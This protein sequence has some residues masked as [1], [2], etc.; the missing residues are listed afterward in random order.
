MGR[1]TLISG[2][3]GFF[4][5]VLTVGTVS[6]L[7]FSLRLSFSFS[8]LL[9][10]P[11]LLNVLNSKTAAAES[12]GSLPPADGVGSKFLRPGDPHRPPRRDTN[13]R[14]LPDDDEDE[15]ESPSSDPTVRSVVASLPSTCVLAVF[16]LLL[17]LLPSNLT[18][19]FSTVSIEA[20]SASFLAA[21]VEKASR[22][23]TSVAEDLVLMALPFARLSLSSFF[24][25]GCP[26]V[27]VTDDNAFVVLRSGVLK[28]CSDMV[29]LMP[30]VRD[31]VETVAVLSIVDVMW[32]R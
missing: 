7:L 15:D 18:C 17:F 31:L 26:P 10:R 1:K 27:T 24:S 3:P 23:V 19:L 2:L 8:Q 16:L 29:L 25:S 4:L 32:F 28:S 30:A 5:S 12:T 20:A 21:A 22:G 9:F 14:W 11:G 13:P 6:P